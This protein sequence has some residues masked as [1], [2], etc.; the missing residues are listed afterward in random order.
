MPSLYA[1]GYFVSTCP[2]GYS[3]SARA[4]EEGV[5][6][7]QEVAIG[8]EVDGARH[9]DAPSLEALQAML[10]HGPVDLLQHVETQLHL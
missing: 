6:L 8:L 3:R 9:V 4:A 5:A 10:E 7:C 2:E 1:P